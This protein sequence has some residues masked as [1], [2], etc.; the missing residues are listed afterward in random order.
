M[1]AHPR[2]STPTAALAGQGG[3]V[4][5]F[6][7]GTCRSITREQLSLMVASRR[8]PAGVQAAHHKVAH[9]LPLTAAEKTT[10]GDYLRTATATLFT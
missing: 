5:P 9:G 4:V 6:A 2:R 1:A 10:L 3:G 8:A 7:D